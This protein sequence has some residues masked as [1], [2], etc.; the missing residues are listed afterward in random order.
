MNKMKFLYAHVRFWLIVLMSLS[1]L[2]TATV[3]A[4][5]AGTFRNPVLPGFNPDPSI[6]R[7][8]D[9]YYMTTS[10]FT[11]FPGLPVYHSRD[12]VHWELIG[13]GIDRPSVLNMDGL[14]DNDGTW[15]ATIRYSRGVFYII[16]TANKCGGNFYITATNPRGPW[17]DP[18]WLKD[19]SGI[20]PS[21]FFD[22]DGRCYYTGNTWNLKSSWPGQCAIWIQ[23]LDLN[24]GRLVGERKII[25][26]GHAA[27]A[28][29]AEGPH[30][31][32]INGQYMLVMA[33]G[34]SGLNH[35]VTVMHSRNVFGPYTPDMIN[36]VITHR[37]LGHDY[38]ITNIGHADLVQ[39]Q[40]GE[41][42][43]VVLG[44]RMTKG[45]STLGR[46]TFLCRVKFENGTPIF[47]PGYGIVRSEQEL[48]DLPPFKAW[49]Q[50]LSEKFNGSDIPRGWY[51]VRI[52]K[53]V[54][55]S[56]S[57][58][59]LNLRIHPQV[60]D[61][62]TNSSM[63]LRKAEGLSF[64]ATVKMSFQ[65]KCNNEQAGLVLY[66][67]ANGYFTLMKGMDKLVL[68]RKCKGVK[69]V[70]AVTSYFDR[71]VLLRLTV[72]GAEV[73]FSYSHDGNV[74]TYIGGREGMT[75]VAD[76]RKYNKFNG[77]GVGMYATS[78]GHKTKNTAHYD[79]FEYKGE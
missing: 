60:I 7:V 78:Q 75:A 71:E 70:V 46:E 16:T 10:S 42:Y 39:T 69:A 49:Q 51:F 3:F 19:A 24:K 2:L 79:W 27:N 32:K 12:L 66:R 48:P 34:G 73:R 8:G 30:I 72:E 1:T 25:S 55:C 22:D 41:W 20:D 54:F 37:H 77:L 5:N 11:W 29:Y 44:N 33:E 45:M 23:E 31:Y 61:S 43:A 26:Y 40:G 62:L 74:W 9:D 50:P 35:A 13:H 53:D 57:N 65:T 15:A 6:C 28:T 63:I 38:P 21:L 76:D 64:S 59:A 58:G 36:P 14:N 52:P 4:T 17:S 56:V 47:N 18:V 68:T 67:T